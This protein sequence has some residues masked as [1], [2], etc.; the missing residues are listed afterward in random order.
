MPD[1]RNMATA[2]LEEIPESHTAMTGL[3]L[4][5]VSFLAENSSNGMF[6]AL[7]MW[8]RKKDSELRR[9]TTIASLLISATASA[10]DTAMRAVTSKG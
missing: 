7:T 4:P 8:P 6:F 1:C 5:S 9:S 2:L 10:G 3:D